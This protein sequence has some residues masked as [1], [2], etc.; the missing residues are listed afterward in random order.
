MAVPSHQRPSTEDCDQIT[1]SDGVTTDN[2]SSSYLERAC[3]CNLA[4]DAIVA[5]LVES[6][7]RRTNT[8][9]QEGKGTKQGRVKMYMGT[10]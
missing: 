6:I 8:K 2:I 10:N 4:M 1:T 3:S 7:P 5:R 9:K